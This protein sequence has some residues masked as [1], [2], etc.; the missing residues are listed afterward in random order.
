MFCIMTPRVRARAARWFDTFAG[1]SHHRSPQIR[2]KNRRPMAKPPAFQFYAKDWLSSSSVRVMGWA[3]K[4]LFIELLALCWD[5]EGLPLDPSSV[6]KMTRMASQTWKALWPEVRDKFEEVNGRLWNPKLLKIWL[7]GRRLSEKRSQSARGSERTGFVYAAIK[8]GANLVKIGISSDPEKRIKALYRTIPPGVE[9]SEGGFPNWESAELIGMK[10]ATSALERQAHVDLSST[11]VGGEWFRAT[12]ET[13]NWVSDQ[14]SDKS[15]I[16]N[17]TT[18]QNENKTPTK[19]LQNDSL[20]LQSASA[21]AI[22][23]KE[24]KSSML[25]DLKKSFLSKCTDPR[26]EIAIVVEIVCERAA[27]SGTAIKS[28]AYIAKA[29]ETFDFEA[30]QDKEELQQRLRA[31]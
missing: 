12:P 21:S 7:D 27:K 4:G 11:S 24:I 22:T 14:L 26:G 16:S 28:E 6:R 10:E 8:R 20:H 18:E 29:V 5:N 2:R 15:F 31:N 9:P 17:E 30:G 25:D 19:P 3:A 13:L 23:T 1:S